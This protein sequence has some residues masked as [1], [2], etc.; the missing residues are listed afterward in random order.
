MHDLHLIVPSKR[1]AMPHGYKVFQTYRF[2]PGGGDLSDMNH[3]MV[4][5]SRWAGLSISVTADLGT[6]YKVYLEILCFRDLK[7]FKGF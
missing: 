3:G 1:R 4:V 7:Y 6:V 5:G 2:C